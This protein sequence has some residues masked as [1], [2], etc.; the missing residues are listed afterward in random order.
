MTEPAAVTIDPGEID[1]VIFDMDGVLTDTAR[2]HQAAWAQLFDEYL[3]ASASRG[4]TLPR[5][6]PRDPAD[7]ATAW[8]LANRKNRYF[9]LV[10]VD[11]RR[12]TPTERRSR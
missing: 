8:G 9:P 5:G 11:L 1:A 12:A 7:T 4:A 10:T 2:V 6:T 3:A